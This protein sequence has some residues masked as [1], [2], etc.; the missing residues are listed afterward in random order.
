M[1][2]I[3]DS[4]NLNK[5]I[6]AQDAK[7]GRFNETVYDLA[8]SEIRAGK[9]ES[10]WIWYIWPQIEG[11]GQSHNSK[12]YGIP[13][14]EGAINYL[15]NKILHDRLMEITQSLLNIDVH[16]LEKVMYHIDCMKV[17]S[18]ITLFYVAALISLGG[19]SAECNLFLSVK[20]KYFDLIG[21]CELT[22]KIL[23]EHG[24]IE[25]YRSFIYF[26]EYI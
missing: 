7:V 1:E 4:D 3:N 21:F 25:D 9:K 24:E 5:Y 12:T 16:R 6:I 23:Y 15:N 8:L 10:H 20:E 26:D 11:L 19:D 22:L 13:G 17:R 14:L 18:C 2:Y